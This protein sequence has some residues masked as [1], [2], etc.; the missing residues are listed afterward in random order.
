MPKKRKKKYHDQVVKAAREA[1]DLI[2]DSLLN[3]IV[4]AAGMQS[5]KTEFIACMHELML[6]IYPETLIPIIRYDF[7]KQ[8]PA[9][10]H[11]IVQDAIKK[12]VEQPFKLSEGRDRLGRASQEG[13]EPTRRL[14]GRRILRLSA[15]ST[16]RDCH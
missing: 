15:H 2:T 14:E 16:D 5:G 9:I 3:F 8:G 11:K 4:V 1:L 7:L 10:N 6:E 12:E 13:H